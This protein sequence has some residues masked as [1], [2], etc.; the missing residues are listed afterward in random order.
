MPE[1]S[2]IEAGVPRGRSGRFGWTPRWVD[3]VVV[4]HL[5]GELDLSTSAELRER[6]MTVVGSDRAEVVVLDLS[7]VCFIDAHSVGLIVAAS[8]AAQDHGRRLEVDGLHGIPATVFG[9]LGLEPLLAGR[10]CRDAAGRS[11][12]GR[13]ERANGVPARWRSAGGA[14]G[15]G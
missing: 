14:N 6:L 7:G 4:V 8:A 5:A 9:V 11:A 2:D 15:A 12:R 10:V 13:H 3:G 1:M